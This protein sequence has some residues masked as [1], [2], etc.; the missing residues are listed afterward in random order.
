[1]VDG[2]GLRN[3]DGTGQRRRHLRKQ[4]RA[5]ARR[6]EDE[7]R[8]LDTRVRRASLDQRLDWRRLQSGIL[9]QGSADCLREERFGEDVRAEVAPLHDGRRRVRPD[10]A[11]HPTRQRVVFNRRA[12]GVLQLLLE[13]RVDE[14]VDHQVNAIGSTSVG[15]RMRIAETQIPALARVHRDRL[16]V[17]LELHVRVGHHGNVQSNPS[18]FSRQIKVCVRLDG[19]AR[20]ELHEPDRMQGTLERRHDLLEVRTP[21]EQGRVHERI[22]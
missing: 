12:L 3:H 15:D 21:R 14:G 5:A 4:R 16:A 18:K 10:R 19:R 8:R 17:Q 2:R 13:P 7:C 20:R 11:R 22:A 6:V 9:S 1:M